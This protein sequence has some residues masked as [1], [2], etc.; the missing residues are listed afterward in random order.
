MYFL[1][2][3]KRIA[4]V[5]AVL[6]FSMWQGKGHLKPMLVKEREIAKLAAVFLTSTASPAMIYKRSGGKTRSSYEY[7]GTRIPVD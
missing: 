1:G 4:L 3:A 2:K 5:T 7:L 6:I